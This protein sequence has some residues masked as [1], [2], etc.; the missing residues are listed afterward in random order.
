MVGPHEG[1]KTTGALHQET[2]NGGGLFRK[3]MV[4]RV[5]LLERIFH[6]TAKI[7]G[8][9]SQRACVNWDESGKAV[10]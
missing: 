3:L 7:H 6:A 1:R 8:C 10:R 9:R 4:V 5:K 2:L